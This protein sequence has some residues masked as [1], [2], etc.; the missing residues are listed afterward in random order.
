MGGGARHPLGNRGRFW[1]GGAAAASVRS[2]A[3]P[4]PAHR[5]TPLRRRVKQADG[6]RRPDSKSWDPPLR[7]VDEPGLR[8][9]RDGVRSG[10]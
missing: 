4:E 9:R 8:E 5:P 10:S 1:R 6:P 7:V 3:D 2:A